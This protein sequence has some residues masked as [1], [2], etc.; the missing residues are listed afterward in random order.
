MILDAL[1]TRFVAEVLHG[2]THIVLTGKAGTGKSTALCAAVNSAKA[3]GMDV[4][5]MAPTAMAASIH[6]DNGLESG[7]I[8]HALK[9]NPVREPLPRKLLSLCGT[10]MVWGGVPDQQRLLFI[11][12]CSMVG[13][14]LFEILGRDLGDSRRPF[15]GRRVIAVGDW[16]QLPPVVGPDET[17]MASAMPELGRFGP[18]DGCILHHP[19][20]R[21][22]PPVSVVLKETHRA[23]SEWFEA[24]NR[25]RDCSQRSSLAGLNICP[26][27]ST[28]SA[29]QESVRMCFRRTTAHTR[30]A[31]KIA[32][33]PGRPYFLRLR[34]GDM[35]LREGCDV[36]V[37]SNRVA[38]GY[39]NGS[40]AVFRGVNE[41][42][43]VVLDDGQAVRML[44]DGNWGSDFD[45]R[46]DNAEHAMKAIHLASVMLGRYGRVLESSAVKWLE[47]L[48][49]PA[50]VCR[51]AAFGEGRIVMQPYFPILPGYALTV[52]KA[53]GMG[54]PGVIIEEDV[55]WNIAP[56]RLPYVA[57]SRVSDG[58]RVS[59]AGFGA[60]S[61]YVRPDPVYA[62]VMARIRAWST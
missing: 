13:L 55:F 11:D 26:S 1:Q 57:L 48:G 9:W 60:D 8:H 34:D 50:N 5:L 37:T 12:E 17:R 38:E 58:S 46:E 49:R 2:K 51:A 15:D 4:I 7:T 28:R 59:L 42:G 40:R 53:Q 36:I 27:A 20:F 61:A 14:W 10:D 33:L 3:A 43:T 16:A 6:R 30:N 22:C 35:E 56:A 52:H 45:G 21:L 29:T 32:G 41:E 62:G 25:V 44:A 19:M 31:E 39:I 18:I 54:L 47:E 23:N 24:L